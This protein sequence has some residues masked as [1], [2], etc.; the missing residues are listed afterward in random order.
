MD[1]VFNA[2][3][4]SDVSNTNDTNTDE[5]IDDNEINDADVQIID[6]SL[7]MT[8]HVSMNSDASLLCNCEQVSLCLY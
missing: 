4:D 7:S 3:L 8:Q 5:W 6:I 2:V 1:G